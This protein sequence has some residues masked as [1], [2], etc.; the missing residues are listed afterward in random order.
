[1]VGAAEGVALSYTARHR[2]GAVMLRY[3]MASR[4][5]GERSVTQIFNQKYI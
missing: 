3:K 1:M 2:I 5:A 4:H